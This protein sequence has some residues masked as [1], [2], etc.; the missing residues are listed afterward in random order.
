[1]LPRILDKLHESLLIILE[2][3]GLPETRQRLLEKWSQFEKDGGIGKTHYDKRMT[4][5]KA[6][7]STH[8]A[9]GQQPSQP[10]E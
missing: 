1:V 8:R 4:T 2:A 6:S 3:A 9:D 5:S 10:G 7:P